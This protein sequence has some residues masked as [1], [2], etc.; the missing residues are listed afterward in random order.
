MR[1]SGPSARFIAGVLLDFF[2]FVLMVISEL[3]VG[4]P[5]A[6]CGGEAW[7]SRFPA[8]P[9]GV[10]QRLCTMLIWNSEPS[11]IRST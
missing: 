8:T 5:V 2:V 7:P 3:G 4:S 11:P 1:A 10:G 6:R 9:R